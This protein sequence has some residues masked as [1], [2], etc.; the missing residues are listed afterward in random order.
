M[1]ERRTMR[2]IRSETNV[3]NLIMEGRKKLSVSGVDDV[4][5]F[6]ETEIVLHT[7]MGV[8][9]IE[10]EKLHINKLT[11]DN[12]EVLIDGELNGVRYTYESENSGGFLK[13]LFK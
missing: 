12:G 5:S 13:R 8:L 2:N 1:E 6:N 7:N 3:H 10:G 11:I 9:I 4:E